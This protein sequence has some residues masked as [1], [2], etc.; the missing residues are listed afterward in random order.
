M[1]WGGF[2]SV[3]EKKMDIVWE[4]DDWGTIRAQTY[5]DHVLTSTIWPIWY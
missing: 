1:I 4:R 3:K 2:L 5:I